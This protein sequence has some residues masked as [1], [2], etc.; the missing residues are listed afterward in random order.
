MKILF[1][2]GNKD[3]FREASDILGDGCEVIG[4]D[5]DIPEIQSTDVKEVTKDKLE[6]N[7]YD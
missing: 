4:K 7:Q 5:M 6:S 1:L 3:K 2:T